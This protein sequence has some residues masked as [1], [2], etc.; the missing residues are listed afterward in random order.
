MIIIILNN[1][2]NYFIINI[3]L[4]VAVVIVFSIKDYLNFV[5]VDS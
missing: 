2:K 3:Y 5:I 1:I 4:A